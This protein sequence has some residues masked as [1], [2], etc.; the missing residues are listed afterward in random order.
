MKDQPE[1]FTLGKGHVKFFYDKCGY[2]KKRYE[3]LYQE[4]LER[5]F[6]VTY[7]GKAWEGV[8]LEFMGDYKPTE[9]A[10]MLIEERIKERS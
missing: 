4:C 9:E 10:R 1:T 5:G 6:N 3:L 2:L 7:Y 8:P